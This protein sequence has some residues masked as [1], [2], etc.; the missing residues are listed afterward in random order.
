MKILSATAQ[1][2]PNIALIKYWGNR[3]HFLRIPSNSSLSMNLDGLVSRTQVSFDPE[4]ESD[5]LTLND[6]EIIGPA[7]QRVSVLLDRVRSMAVLKQFA[8]VISSNNFPTGTGIASSASAFAALTMAATTAAGLKLS[9]RE[10]SSLARTASGSACRSIPGGYVEW[11]AGHDD[12]D[13]YAFSIAPPDHWDLGDCIAITSET[14]KPVCSTEG[15]T[16]ADTSPLQA[17]RVETTP[18]RLAQCRQAILERDFD[19]LANVI[20]LDTN[21][22]HAV[23]ITSKPPLLYWLPATLEV[24]HAVL[25]WR[26]SGLPVCYTID[27][28]PNVHVICPGEQIELVAT[29]LRQITG[30]N[31]VLTAHPGGEAHLLPETS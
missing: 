27:A 4:L 14:H 25:D 2:S 20:E 6:Q 13:S 18:Q 21:M 30:V 22:M 10:L 12:S 19:S 15:H 11:Q 24:M 26:S 3:D 1:A 5:Q 16:L 29:R 23:M 28:G 7:L 8:N 17:A 9:T 31:D